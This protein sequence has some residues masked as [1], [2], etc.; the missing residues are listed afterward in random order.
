MNAKPSQHTLSLQTLHLASE[1]TRLAGEKGRTVGTAESCTGGLIGAALTSV[2]GSSAVF[3]GGIIAYDNAVKANSLN[4]SHGLLTEFGAVSSEVAA[5]MAREAR[6]RLN[7][8][9][10]VSVTAI[11]G[12]SGGS[13][14][15]PVGT[16]WMG[17]ACRANG[18]VNVS[19]Q[20]YFF[21]HFSRQEVREMTVMVALETL[22]KVLNS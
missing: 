11:A 12:P 19:T 2:P 3:H 15:K 17:L 1:I 22:L 14:E 21:D 20:H 4:V 9:I 5:V 16:V 10:A 7:V 6:A 18:S 13:T 8:D